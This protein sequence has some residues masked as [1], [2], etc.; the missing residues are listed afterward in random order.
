[1]G[2]AIRVLAHS[3]LSRPRVAV[4]LSAAGLLVLA[5]L[6]AGA[7]NKNT[8][9]P[10]G[11]LPLTM[12][13][14]HLGMH[15]WESAAADALMCLAICLEALGL[16]GMMWANS[17]GW[18]PKPRKLLGAAVFAVAVI[19][20]VTPVG[21]S[22]PG[23]YA[24]YGRIAASGHDPYTTT[25]CMMWQ[26]PDP[27]E[28]T[29]NGM[30]DPYYRQ[31]GQSWRDT[32][33]VYGPVATWVQ[34]LSAAV[35]G[36]RPWLTIW[37]GQIVNGSVFVA[38]GCLLL[39][40]A[41]NPVRAGLLW[42]ANPLLIQVLVAGGHVDTLMTGCAVVAIAISRRGTSL[43]HD[44]CVGFCI[45]IAGGIK[46]NAVFVAFGIAA[47]LLH[48]RQWGRLMR[49]GAVAG[50]TT[51]SLYCFSYGLH[52]LSPLSNASK[53]VISP[54]IWRLVQMLGDAIDRESSPATATTI[55]LLWPCLMLALAWYLY[56]RLSPDVPTIVAGTC[57]LTFAW[58]LVAPWSLP[59]YSS[60]AWVTLALLPRNTLTR[61]LTLATT[62]Q[63]LLHSH[64][65]WDPTSPPTPPTP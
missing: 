65:G 7:P 4:S 11:S 12:L 35:G 17:G 40:V 63:A 13:A 2:R 61:W 62:A 14:H 1:M 39:R 16:A 36:P 25:P 20:N 5:L 48:N 21:S 3:P 27:R 24:A 6:G 46:V 53:L 44:L 9:A 45:G 28:D 64:G 29:C 41:A 52:A 49:T 33:S 47:P 8:L 15:P 50:A 10:G 60:V 56:R 43:R 55:G 38:I 58:V 42:V 34:A 59:W 54:S 31:V 57:A 23:S 30:G 32:P 22:D 19:V 26:S 51:L 37:V 18:A